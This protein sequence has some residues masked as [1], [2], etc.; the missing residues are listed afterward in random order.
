MCSRT[1]LSSAN[2]TSFLFSGDLLNA[3]PQRTVNLF[4]QQVYSFIWQSIKWPLMKCSNDIHLWREVYSYNLSDYLL[5][6]ACIIYEHYFLS[7]FMPSSSNHEHILSINMSLQQ[8]ETTMVLARFIL[9][10]IPHSISRELYFENKMQ[11]VIFPNR[12]TYMTKKSRHHC[13]MYPTKYFQQQKCHQV[14]SYVCDELGKAF[15]MQ[16]HG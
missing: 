8:L 4:F 1:Y 9:A 6:S 16:Q 12:N 3:L 2:G 15:K 7:S 13:C 14:L 5:V 11:F 10:Q